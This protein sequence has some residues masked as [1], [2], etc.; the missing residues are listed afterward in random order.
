MASRSQRHP[1][2]TQKAQII[3]PIALTTLKFKTSVRQV[4]KLNNKPT[5]GEDIHR[6]YKEFLQIHKNIRRSVENRPGVYTGNLY[7][8]NSEFTVNL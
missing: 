5:F 3:K 2:K 8:M 7:K 4:A 6:T 1:N